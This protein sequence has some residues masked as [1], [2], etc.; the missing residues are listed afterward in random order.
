MRGTFP[1]STLWV[2]VLAVAAVVGG[3]EGEGDFQ[4]TRPRGRGVVCEVS[5]AVSSA[6]VTAASVQRALMPR[7]RKATVTVPSRPS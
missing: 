7:K 2:R 5:H 3:L 6:P 4:R 1:G